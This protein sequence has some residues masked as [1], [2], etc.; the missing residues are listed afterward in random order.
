MGGREWE[1]LESFVVDG[2]LYIYIFLFSL[3]FTEIL[4]DLFILSSSLDRL[5]VQRSLH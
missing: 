4:Y 5:D 2:L 3:F 1:T